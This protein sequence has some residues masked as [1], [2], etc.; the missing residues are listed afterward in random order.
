MGKLFISEHPLIK[1]KMALL[2]NKETGTKEFKEVI[3]EVALLLTYE[4]TRD[5]SLIDV[6][7]TTPIEEADC[8]MIEKKVAIVPILRAGI[9]LTDGVQK[10]LPTAKM[11]HI[12][13]YRDPETFMPI[14]YYCKLPSDLNESEVFLVDPMLATGG[15]VSAAIEF[16]K[17]RG[18]KKITFI[19]ILAAP[20]GVKAV[21]E[22]HPE[23]DIYTASLDKGLN[24]H[25]Y[26]I[27]GLGDAG[28]RI[29]GTK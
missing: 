1:H 24:D 2:R 20:E 15:T 7:V 17:E 23:V 26:I 6:K 19:C 18:A 8:Q 12:G 3:G 28:D 14:E 16:L 10:L 25:G 9:G 11:G 21:Q 13:L 29:F 27:P 22:A 4:A 5:L